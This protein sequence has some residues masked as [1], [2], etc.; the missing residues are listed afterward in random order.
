M[1]VISP[2]LS[3]DHIQFVEQ[4]Q[5]W[6]SAINTA[7]QPLIA[8]GAMTSAYP[9]AI[10]SGK[11]SLGPYFVLAPQIAMPHAR[12]EEGA[13]ALGLSVLMVRAGVNFDA[14]E[15]DPVRLLFM[16]SAPDSYSHLEMI[17]QLAELLSDDA[18]MAQLLNATSKQQLISLL[19]N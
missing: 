10:I 12:P 4:L 6:K 14:D 15:N 16:F 8:S 7:A 3:A 11:E 17:S 9:A 18:M 19:V 13:L 5:D 2:W 1:S